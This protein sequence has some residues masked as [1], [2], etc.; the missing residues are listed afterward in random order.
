MNK[1][2]TLRDDERK[3][4][5]W[6]GLVDYANADDLASN[7]RTV[8]SVETL[9]RLCLPYPRDEES[10][11]E[12]EEIGSQRKLTG[13][14]IEEIFKQKALR[15]QSDVRKLLFWLC[16][17]NVETKIILENRPGCPPLF[18]SPV[19][20]LNGEV[21]QVHWRLEEVDTN[22]DEDSRDLFPFYFER[23]VE[24][25]TIIGP[26]CSFLV[27]QLEPRFGNES[28]QA[29]IR[30][31]EREGCGRF[32]LPERKGR[33]RFCSDQ[34]RAMAYQGSREDWNEYMR[35]YRKLKAQ[36]KRKGKPR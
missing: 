25:P 14:P 17:P 10:L 36:R 19:E 16:K 15:Y 8:K 12:F 1:V 3:R 30:I 2:A 35:R 24:H 22:F 4:R 21:H 31:C 6:Q 33:K 7:A 34:C 23:T 18:V 27:E 26:I 5:I 9:V 11:I 29:P 28:G 32:T 13:E 20:Y